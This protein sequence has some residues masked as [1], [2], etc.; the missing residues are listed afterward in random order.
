MCILRLAYFVE[1]GSIL[2][3]TQIFV[4]LILYAIVY[5]LI[6]FHYGSLYVLIHTACAG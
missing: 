5:V 2:V 1:G 6:Y 4:I 3:L